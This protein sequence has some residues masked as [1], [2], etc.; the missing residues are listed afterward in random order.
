[1]PKKRPSKTEKK[2]ARRQ[3]AHAAGPP[4]GAD[5]KQR[6]A[7]ANNGRHMPGSQNR[8]KTSP[9]GRKN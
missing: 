1:M 4:P 5:M 7:W 6:T 8:R 3:K 9:A 2:L